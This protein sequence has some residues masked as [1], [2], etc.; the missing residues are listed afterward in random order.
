MCELGCASKVIHESSAESWKTL[1]KVLEVN[2][3]K[4][5]YVVIARDH[6]AGQNIYMYMGNNVFR[7][8]RI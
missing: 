5:K 3:D 1:S 2:A 7:V 8:G 4:T 6:H